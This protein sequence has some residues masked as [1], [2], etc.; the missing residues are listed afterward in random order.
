[1]DFMHGE[2]GGLL[3]TRMATASRCELQCHGAP[4]P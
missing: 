1:M 4:M 3:I 2:G